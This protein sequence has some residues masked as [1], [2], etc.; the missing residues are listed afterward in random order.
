MDLGLGGKRVLVTGGSRG[1]GLAIARGLSS[2][3]CRL[4]TC[5][6]RIA[7]Y[8]G[9]THEHLSADLETAEGFVGLAEHIRDIWGYPD[10]LVNNLGGGG[11]WGMDRD[12]LTP[13]EVWSQVYW[14]NAGVATEL[15]RLCLPHMMQK[16]WGRV[17]TIASI[18]GREGGGR[19]PFNMA[20]AS[21][22]SLM[23]C[24]ALD[25]RY[26]GIT[27]NSVCPGPIEVGNLQES[28]RMGKPEDVANLVAFLCSDRA[29][30][31]SGASIVVDGGESRSF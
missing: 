22:I 12:D 15:T 11:R 16:K 19:A 30:W 27:F 2:E 4:S 8:S 9:F 7:E 21:E 29:R 3:G 17:V 24:L 31:I 14:K 5:S 23:K 13:T 1:I 10:I 6:R 28:G 26:E 20:K 25:R 18:Y